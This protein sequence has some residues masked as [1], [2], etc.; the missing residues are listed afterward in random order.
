MSDTKRSK[1]AADGENE[2]SII[3]AYDMLLIMAILK[4]YTGKTRAFSISEITR[5]LNEMFTD[6]SNVDSVLFAER[7]IY[8]KVDLLA[9][10]A[11]DDSELNNYIN[12]MLLVLTGGAVKYRSANGILSGINTSGKGSQRRYFFEPLL[13]NSDLDMICSTLMSSRYLS[14]HEK[15]YLL[16]RLKILKSEYDESDTDEIN[17]TI[18]NNPLSRRTHFPEKPVGKYALPSKTEV[19]LSHIRT[20]YDAI[21]NEFRI[22]VTYGIYDIR[23]KTGNIDFHPRNPEK[24]YILNPYAM[25]WN[26][27][28]YYLIATHQNY[29]NP[30]HFRIDR[31]IDVKIHTVEKKD[32]SGKLVNIPERRNKIPPTLLPFFHRQKKLMVFDAISYTNTYPDMKIYGERDLVECCFE[33]TTLSLQILIDNFG[34]DFRLGE[35]PIPHP[36]NET[37]ING[38]PKRFLTATISGIQRE[39]AIDFAVL[40]SGSLTLLSPSDL[41]DEVIKRLRNTF[42]K[43]K[44]DYA[45]YKQNV[46]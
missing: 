27:G 42:E 20:I 4:I 10:A 21:R 30:T 26:D 24:P 18:F 13:S 1:Y 7:T 17:R 28:E 5:E 6:V 2:K 31:I 39:C 25:I 41:V 16:S 9:S 35:S 45:Y 14:E 33:C 22:E 8:R 38:K 44:S 46:F 29:E 34:H 43:Y 15:H 36:E 23:E 40:H 12:R 3:H 19:M 11:S 37:E 32:K